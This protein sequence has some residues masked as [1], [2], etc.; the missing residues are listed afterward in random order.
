MK[1]LSELK[2]KL[3]GEPDPTYTN[4]AGAVDD[5]WDSAAAGT[6]P[7]AH[8][9]YTLDEDLIH[10]S[11]RMPDDDQELFST[12]TWNSTDIVIRDDY[13]A[14][15]QQSQQQNIVLVICVKPCAAW[16]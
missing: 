11:L 4:T 8:Q 1:P 16:R 7:T 3:F 10:Q 14:D 5:F 13:D 6:S 9:Q 15:F 2:K 12:P